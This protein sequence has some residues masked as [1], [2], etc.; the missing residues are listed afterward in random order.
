ML[1]VY[2]LFA[3]FCRVCIY[4]FFMLQEMALFSMLAQSLDATTARCAI[5]NHI[6]YVTEKLKRLMSL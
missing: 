3:F 1:F 6:G 2:C 5:S 4:S